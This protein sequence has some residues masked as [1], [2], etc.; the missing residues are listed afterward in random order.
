MT[1]PE[2]SESA[3][4]G[5]TD[6][7]SCR[8][9]LEHLPLSNV[10]AAQAQIMRELGEFNRAPVSATQRLAVLEALREAV[11]FVQIEQARRFS[12]RAL[13]MSDAEAEAFAATI[14]MWDQ[15]R[16][17]YERCLDAAINRDAA[18]RAQAGL[19]CQRLLFYV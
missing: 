18:M 5:F 6:A 14:G 7:A 15:M 17:G 4:P 8:A 9:W 13:P 19:V 1:L 2:L 12:N 16:L 11:N 10:A 3:S